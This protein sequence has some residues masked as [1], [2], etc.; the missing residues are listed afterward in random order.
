MY[1][2]KETLMNRLLELTDHAQTLSPA[3]M[4]DA[5]RSRDGSRDGAFVYAV[6][7]TGIYCRPSCPSRRP[8]HGNVHY[9]ANSDAAQHAGF[10]PCRRC[11][12]DS[13]SK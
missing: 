12:A 4:W 6:V 2:V 3:E 9:F 1:V 11:Q 10:R 5:V 8:L 7:T 13:R